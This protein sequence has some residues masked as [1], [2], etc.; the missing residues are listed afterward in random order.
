MFKFSGLTVG[1]PLIRINFN[2]IVNIKDLKYKEKAQRANKNLLF[3]T[4]EDV[5]VEF[6]RDRLRDC[7]DFLITRNGR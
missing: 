3:F 1:H 2:I 6:I 4:E 7:K 5:V